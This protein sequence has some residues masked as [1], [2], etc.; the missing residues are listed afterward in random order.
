M[1]EKIPAQSFYL[2]VFSISYFAIV[3]AS[4]I[5]F[6]MHLRP[7]ELVSLPDIIDLIFYPPI[8]GVLL[9]LLYDSTVSKSASMYEKILY[10][11]F[12]ILHIE[13]HGIHW[14]SNALDVL[15]EREGISGLV[16]DF[17]CILLM[18]SLVIS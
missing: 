4:H 3:I 16:S 9:Y 6:G 18:K 8:I 15:I 14:S 13:G 12:L 17:F 10:L 2:L 5:V 1:N 7:N 11:I